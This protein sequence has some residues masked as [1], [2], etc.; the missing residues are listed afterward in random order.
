MGLKDY[1]TYRWFKGKY[2]FGHAETIML[3]AGENSWSSRAINRFKDGFFRV[4]SLSSAVCMADKI[5][6]FSP[7]YD[8]FRRKSFVCALLKL[9]KGNPE[10]DHAQMLQKISYQ[11][12]RLTD[13]PT[14]SDYLSVLEK[15]YNYKTRSE[16]VRFDIAA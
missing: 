12:A 2:K 16:Y 1:Q 4:K 15:I 11:S 5:N 13:Q 8:G 3:L 14:I 7:Y 10:Y 9:M 6:E